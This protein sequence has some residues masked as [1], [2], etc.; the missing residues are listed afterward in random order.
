[1]SS[2]GFSQAQSV[3]RRETALWAGLVVVS[4]LVV[5]GLGI[6]VAV[7]LAFTRLRNSSMRIRVGLV[8]LGA[9][10]F[11]VQLLG[12]MAGSTQMHISPSSP[13]R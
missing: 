3:S 2:S 12:L 10:V 7:A 9:T 13:A 4:G 11:V 6:I 8:A 5:P 1:M